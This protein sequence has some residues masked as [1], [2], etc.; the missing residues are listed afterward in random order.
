[1]AS[2]VVST[3]EPALLQLRPSMRRDLPQL[4]DRQFDVLVVGAG[5]QGATIAWDASLR[6]L[7]VALVDQSDFGSG[8]SANSLRIVHGGLRY[9]ARADFPRMRESIRERGALLRIAPDL[10]EPL[11]VLVPTSGNS[12]LHSR[13]AFAIG[14]AAND[15]V[16]WNRNRGLEAQRHLPRGRLLSRAEC[17]HQFPWFPEGQLTGGAMWYDARLRQPHRLTLSF[18][19]S[20]SRQGA[21]PANYVRVDRLLMGKGVVE[22]AAVTDMI[23]GTTFEI[24]SRAVV[25]AAGPWT[26]GVIA[27]TLGREQRESKVGPT[28]AFALNVVLGRRLSEVAV[29]LQSRR[30]AGTPGSGEN[31]F[32]FMHP[33]PRSTLLGTWYSGSE[34]QGVTGLCE[35]GGHQLLDEVNA[36]CHGLDLTPAD[37]VRYQWGW[38]PLKAGREAGSPLDLADRPLIVDHGL[39]N[40]VRHL[41]SVEAVKYT[42]ARAVAERVVNQVARDLEAGGATCRTATTKLVESKAALDLYSDGAMNQAAILRAIREEMALKLSDIVLRRYDAGVWPAVSRRLVA[43]VAEVA[44]SELGWT[45]QQQLSEIEEVLRQMTSLPTVMEPTG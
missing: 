27:S 24:R 2:G 41:F 9:L 29:G 4:A 18:V 32:L 44:A 35:L 19:C 36:A 7:S 11:P 20:A 28:K 26:K 38:L 23:G 15:L 1:V 45:A 10:V 8:T 34:T 39:A 25:V 40:G 3:P 17:L 14:L 21:V 42:T 31:R 22:G 6:G 16:S 5:V 30:P 12:P 33:Q 37:I 13:L 43:E